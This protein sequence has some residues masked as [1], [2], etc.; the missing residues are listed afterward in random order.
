MCINQR[1]TF[2]VQSLWPTY[3]GASL[4][5]FLFV[6]IGVGIAVPLIVI[7]VL[8]TVLRLVCKL[9]RG[10]GICCEGNEYQPPSQRLTAAPQT[11]DT[12]T[13]KAVP[14]TTEPGPAK[15]TAFA[16]ISNQP[17]DYSTAVSYP[18]VDI[19]PPSYTSES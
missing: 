6:G 10:L 12:S 16:A 1:V 19:P 13:S 5:S 2:C 8:L 9:S 18:T 14:A 15:E 7:G 11:S 17:P 4:F 3:R